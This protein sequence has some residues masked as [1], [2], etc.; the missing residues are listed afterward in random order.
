V[1]SRD[2]GRFE[3]VRRG[4][5]RVNGFTTA[6]HDDIREA[7]IAVRRAGALLSHDSS[8]ALLDLSDNIPN[9]VAPAHPA[10]PPRTALPPDAD[11]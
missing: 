6:E 2:T 4:L 5:Y 10:S 9:A 11:C 3:Q 8:V 7:W 1:S